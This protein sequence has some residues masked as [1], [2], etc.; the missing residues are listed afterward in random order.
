MSV[1]ILSAQANAKYP[2]IGASYCTV[3]YKYGEFWHA[4]LAQHRVAFE[5]LLLPTLVID[6]PTQEPNPLH[7]IKPELF[8][9]LFIQ[10]YSL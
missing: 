2:R 3:L 1:V 7:D 4:R 6:D 8:S 5:S 9:V 10:E